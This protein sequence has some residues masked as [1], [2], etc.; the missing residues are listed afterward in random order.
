MISLHKEFTN[1]NYKKITWA[2]L[3]KLPIKTLQ[4]I[5]NIDKVKYRKTA[6]ELRSYIKSKLEKKDRSVFYLMYN[7]SEL[8]GSVM[9]EIKTISQN[10]NIEP[11]IAKRWSA[12][13]TYFSLNELNVNSKYQK[14]GLGTML[15]ERVI[16]DQR[17][18]HGSRFILIRAV[19]PE[20]QKIT[21]RVTGKKPFVIEISKKDRSGKEIKDIKEVLRSF[22]HSRHRYNL[23]TVPESKTNPGPSKLQYITFDKNPD[24]KKRNVT[25]RIK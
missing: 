14:K 23:F 16:A 15:L 22:A 20:T 18:K 4:D 1:I 9:G 25:R 12:N 21:E 2:D 5:V 13:D 19:F 24:Y 3:E 8:L 11:E 6:E 7:G 10:Y 17:V